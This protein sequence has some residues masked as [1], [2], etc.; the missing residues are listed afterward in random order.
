MKI[1][2]QNTH[3]N[4]FSKKIKY[5]S[6][7]SHLIP[8]TY[9]FKKNIQYDV[10]NNIFNTFDTINKQANNSLHY[11]KNYHIRILTS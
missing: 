8:Y 1:F 2:N 11:E 3:F 6:N 10:N 4:K 7:L 9:I 5:F